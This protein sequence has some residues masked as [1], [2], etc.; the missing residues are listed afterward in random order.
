MKE[1]DLHHI[2]KYNLINQSSC[3]STDGEK[4]IV[5]SQGKHNELDSGPDFSFV[6]VIIGD[7][8]WI[9]N[10]EI[11]VKTSDWFK[12]LHHLDPSY[13]NVI[14]HVVYE[15]DYPLLEGA[16]KCPIIELKKCVNP[17]IWKRI[18]QIQESKLK[19]P[20]YNFIKDVTSLDWKSWQDHLVKERFKRK[21][22]EV[23]LI[24][25]LSDKNW[26]SVV[27]QL[28]SKSLGGVVNK[29]P[30]L[31]LSKQ[32]NISY[33]KKHKDNLFII[34]SLLFGVSGMLEDEFKDLYPLMLKKEYL[35]HKAKF[36]LY[37]M[38][39]FWWKWLRL[40]PSS[41]P[42]IQIALLSSLIHNLKDL[43]NLFQVNSFKKFKNIIDKNSCLSLYWE[44]H[45]K[46]DFPAKEKTKNWG[47][48]VLRRIYINAVIPYQIAKN[49]LIGG[50]DVS[51]FIYKMKSLRSENNIVTRKWKK[52][53]VPIS[54]CFASQAMLQLNKEYCSR[55]KCLNCNIGIR[56]LK[57]SNYD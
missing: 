41:F 19:I 27:F 34:E 54:N 51:Y 11:H 52:L 10:L 46:F 23:E 47:D 31:I 43:E 32:I 18:T 50:K 48:D 29:E 4:V 49:N 15:N 53:N 14:L 1:E 36:S 37:Q 25:K 44:N 8:C 2:W 3:Y 38:E 56:I 16:K 22:K 28:L 35:Y 42:T 13:Q 20:C 40:R 21:V 45:Y 17:E 24:Y 12:H 55:K 9:G 33:L 5:I 26:E 30:F 57:Y 6:K 39:G 7:L